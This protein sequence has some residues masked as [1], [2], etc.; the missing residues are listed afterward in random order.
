MKS[1]SNRKIPTHYYKYC[2]NCTPAGHWETYC[3]VRSHYTVTRLAPASKTFTIN[4]CCNVKEVVSLNIYEFR[5]SSHSTY[6]LFS[7]ATSNS[8]LEGLENREGGVC[9]THSMKVILKVGQGKCTAYY[10]IIWNLIYLRSITDLLYFKHKMSNHAP[11]WVLT[12]WHFY[13]VSIYIL[14][15]HSATG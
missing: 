10:S 1:R 8:S 14:Y 2:R 4:N 12:W 11:I 3:K 9:K 13:C 7:T 15:S 5:S 6:D